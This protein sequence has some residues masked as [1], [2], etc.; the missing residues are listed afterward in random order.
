MAAIYLIRHG[1]ASFGSDN[2][3]ALS[4]KGLQQATAVG[5]SLQQR[6]IEFDAAFAGTMQRHAQ[7]AA[8]C[9]HAMGSPLQPTALPGFNE[10]DH[11]EVF[12][13]HVP[14]LQDKT[15]MAQYLAQ[16]PNPHKT[17]QLEFEKAVSRWRS[18]DFDPDYT[19]TWIQFRTRC[20]DALNQVRQAGAKNI[21]VFSSGGPI[22]TVTGHTMG[23]NDDQ[24]IELNWA[25]MNCSITCLLF[26]KDKISLRYFNDFAHFEARA[27]KSLLTHR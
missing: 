4:E 17:F 18:G 5:E 21:A 20:V 13:R 22:A 23:L 25:I 24:I 27:D 12:A 15:Q 3:D 14:E 26:N 16:F 19:E 1:Q 8:N 6:G 2:Y 9:L 11:E 10:Y 7:T